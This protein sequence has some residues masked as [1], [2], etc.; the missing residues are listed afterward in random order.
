MKNVIFRA[1][2]KGYCDFVYWNAWGE[3][4]GGSGKRKAYTITKGAKTSYYYYIHQ[5]RQVIILETVG[6]STGLTGKNGKKIFE[7][8]IVDVSRQWWNAAGPA[9]IGK[10]IVSVE[11]DEGTCGFYPFSVYDCDCGVYIEA[12]ESEVIGN[13]HDNPELLEVEE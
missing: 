4:T 1:K 5:L 11:F 12:S 6:Q 10:P 13:I 7:G 8:D 9:N 3:L 2:I